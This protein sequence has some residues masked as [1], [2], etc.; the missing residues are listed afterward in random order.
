LMA[1]EQWE[2]WVYIAFMSIFFSWHDFDQYFYW[3]DYRLKTI[4]TMSF[5]FQNHYW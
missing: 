4:D 5:V 1:G 2:P 3:T